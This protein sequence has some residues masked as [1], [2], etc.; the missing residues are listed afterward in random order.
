MSKFFVLTLAVIS[1]AV[2]SFAQDAGMTTVQGC[3]QYTKHHYVLTDSS[4][5]EHQLSGYANRL[6]AHVG[7]EISVTGT[8]AMHS[9]SSTVEGSA[10]TTH[11]IPVFKVS[12]MKHIADT[13]TTPAK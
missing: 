6:K 5:K 9:E 3:L 12:S 10:S 7:H 2:G 4:G 8:E 13:C 1:F 11:Q